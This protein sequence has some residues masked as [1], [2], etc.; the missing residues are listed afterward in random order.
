M[1][2]F[3]ILL[4][5][6]QGGRSPTRF[7][8]DAPH[9]MAALHLC[10]EELDKP[11]AIG[12]ALCALDADGTVRVTDVDGREAIIRPV[13]AEDPDLRVPA[14][15]FEAAQARWLGR[16]PTLDSMPAQALSPPAEEAIRN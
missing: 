2:R 3:Q 5:E 12:N 14:T 13:K 10:L 1:P 9:W 16:L 8:A 15:A 7:S 4:A 6:R 11:W